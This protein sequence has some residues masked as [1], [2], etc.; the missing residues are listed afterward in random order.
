VATKERTMHVAPEEGRELS[1]AG[2]ASRSS[3][4]ATTP[5]VPSCSRKKSR[6]RAA[7]RHPHVHRHEDETLCVLEGEFEFTLGDVTIPASPGS[8]VHAARNVPHQ[9]THVG[10]LPG[11]MLVA[12]TPAGLEAF[13]EEAG[14]EAADGSSS[15][16]FGRVEIEKLLAAA[17]KYGIEMRVPLPETSP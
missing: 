11:R 15:S 7:G 14:E 1:L 16:S 4:S 5:E 2:T 8:V 12:V 10:A 17:P 9:F 3:W 13:F 6:R